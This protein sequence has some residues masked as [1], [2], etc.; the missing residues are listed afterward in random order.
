MFGAEICSPRLTTLAERNE[1]AGARA[2][3]VLAQIAYQRIPQTPTRLLPTHLVVR[4]STGPAPLAP[5]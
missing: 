1:D 3:E 2:V 5:R 4:D